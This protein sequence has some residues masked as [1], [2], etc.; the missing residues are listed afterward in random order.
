MSAQD[1]TCLSTLELKLAN[2]LHNILVVKS[3]NILCT[4][5]IRTEEEEEKEEELSMLASRLLINGVVDSRHGDHHKPEMGPEVDAII[6]LA[7]RAAPPRNTE[8]TKISA[9][10]AVHA[11]PIA[12][13][14][15]TNE[16]SQRRTLLR[17]LPTKWHTTLSKAMPI[18]LP[19]SD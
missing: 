6:R 16:S 10:S 8:D 1:W 18:N 2:H 17:L 5:R 19:F 11:P 13:A 3:H 12:E 14:C 7:D 4:R 9:F 15:K